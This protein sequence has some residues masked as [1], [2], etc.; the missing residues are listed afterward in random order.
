MSAFAYRRGVLHAEDVPL[1]RIAE[2]VGTPFYFYSTATLSGRYRAFREALAG[3]DATICYALKANS[4]PAVIA[5]LAALG[6]GADVVS[7]GELARALAA[8]M[9]P[10]RIVF[11]GVG[12]TAGEMEAALAGRHPPVQCRIRGRSWRRST[13]RRGGSVGARPTA[14]RVNPDVDARTHAKIATGKA[15]NKFGIDIDHAA[16]AA[17]PR[18]PLPGIESS[19]SPSISARSSPSIAPFRVAFERVVESGAALRGAGMPI[20]GSISAAASASPI[21]TSSRSPPRRLRR[22]RARNRRRR[23]ACP[24]DLRAGPRA[25]RRSRRA[26]LPACST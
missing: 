9:P 17:K 3:L 5:T 23:S 21:A 20:D 8:G 15:E 2:A 18:P 26:R 24:L 13:R 1:P 4:N 6:A 10:A 11:A 25:G 16:D 19:G 7:E 22:D 12:K 14:I